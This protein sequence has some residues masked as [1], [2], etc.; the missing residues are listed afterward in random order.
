MA[1]SPHSLTELVDRY[2]NTAAHNDALHAALTA[3]TWA[4][5]LLAAHRRHIETH[6]L[7]FGDPA[8]HTLWR[9]LLAA[10][11]E[12]FGTVDA[13]EIGVFKGQVVSL[14]SLLAKTEGW[15]VRVHAL[16]PFEGQPLRGDRWMRK[17]KQLLLPRFR[18][19][20]RSGDFYAKDN[21]EAIVRR[22]FADFELDFDAVRLV[23]GYS[24][25]APVLALV[26]TDRYQVVYIDGDHTY[27]GAASDIRNFA[28]KVVPGGWLVMDDASFD[29]PG[30]TFW[31][32]YES[33]SRACTLLPSLGLRNVLNVGHN[34]VF[35]R[36]R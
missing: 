6:Q 27:E 3:A 1:P 18:E 23:R 35:E 20:L 13:L 31:K 34:R 21:Y 7:G 10:A 2:E 33:V 5:P 22:L 36:V 19:R 12:R 11:H 28:P 8:F 4:D 15:P 32:G 29:L 26:A 17:L 25:A 14:W 16:S 9:L 30:T 24:T